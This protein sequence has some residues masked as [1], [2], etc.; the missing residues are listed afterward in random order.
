MIIGIDPG[1]TGAVAFYKPTNR[2]TPLEELAIY[3]LPLIQIMNRKQ[4][5][6]VIFTKIMR[7]FIRGEKILF[8]AIEDVH[9]MPN[10]IPSRAFRFGYNAGILLGVLSALNIKVLRVN[11][12][13]W[14]SALNLSSDKKK[15]LT[16]A[17]KLFPSYTHYFQRA[18]DDGRAEAAL[19]AYYARK[20]LY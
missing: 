16:L 14:K 7:T 11:P 9:A 4:I 13:T 1:F 5:D 3:D 10:N 2:N 18:K 8:A 12:A 15:S 6:A 20:C 17:K 19:I